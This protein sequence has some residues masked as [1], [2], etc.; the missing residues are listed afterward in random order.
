MNMQ[1]MRR[2]GVLLLAVLAVALTT[3]GAQ[4]KTGGKKRVAVFAFEDK[5]DHRHHWYWW[6]GQSVG[7]GMSDMLITTLVKSG[8]Y[9]VMERTQMDKLLQEQGL[10]MSG[11]VTPQSAAQAGK[12]LGVEI[13]I[14]GAV[15]EFGYKKMS[16]GG[17]LKKIGIGASVGKQSAVV[18]VDVRFVDVNSGEIIKAEN[19]RKEKSKADIG[20]DVPD[21]RFESET[22][23]DQSLVG[24]ATREAIE[25]IVKLLGQQG[26]GAWSAKIVTVKD[27]QIIIN[28]GRENG[29]N[30]GD[31]FVV[32]RP[33]EELIDPDTGE[34][35]GASEETIGEIKVTDN[36]FGGKG[37]ASAC[38]TVKGSGFAAGDL[39]KEKGKN[40]D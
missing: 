5:T 40:K 18:A 13:A 4:E 27:G 1:T 38:M 33:G 14:I 19:V 16:T 34:S 32:V 35:L 6:T 26:G 25:E 23:F 28:S 36:N 12:M 11:V 2:T 8:K 3:A 31:V 17:A 24:K 7:E 29:V 20:V 9:R 10:G 37:R 22:Q 39:V 30:I 21:L 15:T